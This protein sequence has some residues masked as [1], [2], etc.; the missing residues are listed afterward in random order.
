MEPIG[1]ASKLTN[2]IM[3]KSYFKFLFLSDARNVSFIN[4]LRW[5]IYI[6]NS[7]D[8]TKLSC[9]TPYRRSTTI[10]LETNPL[11]YLN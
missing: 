10:S 6:S 1:Y 5:P 11:Y 8:K 2:S 4:P 7:V 3:Q 9:I